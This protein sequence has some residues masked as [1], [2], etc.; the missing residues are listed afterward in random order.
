MG[1]LAAVIAVAKT[2]PNYCKL[3]I[4]ADSEYVIDRLTKHLKEWENNGWIEIKNME[5]FQCAAYLLK[6][7]TAPTYLEWVKGHQGV[8]GNKESNKLAKEGT[9]KDIPDPLSLHIPDKFDLQGAKL[10][11]LTQATAYRG[12]RRNRPRIPCTTTN[13]NIDLAREVI[14]EHTGN[15]RTIETIWKSIRKAI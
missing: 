2:L 3:T 15:F 7:R 6:K 4:V 8:L 1:K 9:S 11:M 10:E 5:L 14:R 13:W 12:I